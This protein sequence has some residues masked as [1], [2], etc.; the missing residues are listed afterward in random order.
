MLFNFSFSTIL[1]KNSWILFKGLSTANDGILYAE[2]DMNCFHRDDITFSQ[3]I[4]EI[5]WAELLK[6]WATNS[7]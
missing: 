3:N 1:F 7:Q 4:M 5:I 6:D 2:L